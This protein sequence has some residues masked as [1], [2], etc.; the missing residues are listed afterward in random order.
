MAHEKKGAAPFIVVLCDRRGWIT[1]VIRDDLDIVAPAPLPRP[2]SAM[3]V[4]EERT[5]TVNFFQELSRSG[6]A[7]DWE[8]NLSLGEAIRTFHFYAGAAADSYLVVGAHSHR[9]V[10]AFYEVMSRIA[11]DDINAALESMR[12]QLVRARERGERDSDLYDQL[13]RMNNELAD[14][15]RELVKKNA[16]LERLDAEKDRFMGIAA[17]DLRSPASIVT[18]IGRSLAAMLEGRLQPRE[19]ELL[20]A[21][22]RYGGFMV[23]LIDDLLDL[24]VIESGRMELNLESTD[25]AALVERVVRYNRYLAAEREIDLALSG[26]YEGVLARADAAKV[27]QVLNNLLSNAV[28]FSRP[29]SRVEVEIAETEGW[30]RISVKDEGQGIPA[31]ELGGLFKPFGTTSVKSTSGERNTGLGLAIARRIVEAH[32]GRIWAESEVGKGSTFFFTLPLGE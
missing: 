22:E 5:K 11:A 12:E 26:N 4:G 7:L 17:H 13:T 9:Q 10:L 25:L 30:A 20:A 18:M 3:V 24:S 28:K 27:E 8:F 21:V 23:R 32:G 29:G 14:A 16:A 19:R 31:E 1:R 15:H 2:F 6:L